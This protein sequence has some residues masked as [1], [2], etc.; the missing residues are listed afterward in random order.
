LGPG[1]AVRRGATYEMPRASRA[2]LFFPAPDHKRPQST[3]F[4]GGTQDNLILGNNRGASRRR[5]RRRIGKH[6]TVKH[7]DEIYARSYCIRIR[8]PGQYEGTE[9]R[10]ALEARMSSPVYI[11]TLSAR[12]RTFSPQ[13]T[14]IYERRKLTTNMSFVLW[15][16][17]TTR[18]SR[19][20]S[21]CSSG[22]A[23]TCIIVR[24][25]MWLTRSTCR[26]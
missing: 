16:V 6:P 17:S 13:C 22:Q 11:S 18:S 26:L 15:V 14:T 4:C 5:I 7:T 21:A 24:E 2:R 1:I 9:C 12:L 8:H 20:S 10:Q 19:Q 3:T 23:K 25:A